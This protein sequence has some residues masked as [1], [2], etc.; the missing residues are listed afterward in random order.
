MAEPLSPSARSALV[1]GASGFVGR[2]LCQCLREAGLRVSVVTRPG[3]VFPPGV[4]S[5]SVDLTDRASLRAAVA[6]VAPG[7]VFH[8]AGTT[9]ADD[10]QEVNVVYASRLLDVLGDLPAP[11]VAVFA[12]SAAEYG[13]PANPSGV[14]SEGD[15]CHPLSAYGRSKLAQ[16]QLALAAAGRGQPVVV[17]RLF[18]PIGP[19][20]PV[21]SAP[22][23]FVRQVASFGA[24]GGTLT[25]GPLD[26]VRDFTGITA[27]VGALL[28]LARSPLA[29]GR[30]VNVCSGHGVS[31]AELVTRLLR[32][33][34]GPV[35]HVIDPARRGTSTLPVVVGDNAVLRQVGVSLGPLDLTAELRDMLATEAVHT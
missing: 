18:N 9:R 8:L 34:R 14:V 31:M 15:E 35:T 16:T 20:T 29:R 24:A 19:G 17:A 30:I 22:G 26:A 5:V 11:P 13:R 21:T 6:S 32:L 7:V 27:T 1:T 28:A 2:H 4:Q 3:A 33:A 12:G 25:T 10:A 23:D